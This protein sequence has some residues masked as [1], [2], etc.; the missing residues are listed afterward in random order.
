MQSSLIGKIEKAKRYA[1]EPGR[2]TIDSLA[3]TFRGE[4]D[5]HNVSLAAGHWHC[6]CDFF[7]E[8]DVCSH[9]LALEKI[10]RDMLPAESVSAT[11]ALF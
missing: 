4:N 1:Q 7:A 5:T 6:T 8:R 3:S 9:T 11:V 10:L 2:I